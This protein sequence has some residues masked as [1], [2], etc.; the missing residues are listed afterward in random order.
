MPLIIVRQDDAAA[1]L[2]EPL[3]ERGSP[4]ST[5]TQHPIEQ[6]APV[7]DHVQ[8]LPFTYTATTL[9][10]GQVAADDLRTFL[11]ESVGRLLNLQTVGFGYLQSM[12][13]L[14]WGSEKQPS[15]GIPFTLDFQE[16]RV[17]VPLTVTVTPANVRPVV[18]AGGPET[19]DL[20]VQ[21]PTTTSLLYDLGA[22]L[23]MVEER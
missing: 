18:A 3:S 10:L 11:A 4:R 19:A 6:G 16:L 9:V 2:V 14:A 1:I 5:A 20:G 23:G 21:S 17:A 15:N 8:R 13:C 12:V 7:T 22:A